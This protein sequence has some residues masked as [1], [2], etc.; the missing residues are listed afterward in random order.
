M[1]T[2]HKLED[3]LEDA[4]YQ[5][6]IEKKIALLKELAE[7]LDRPVIYQ[8]NN[9]IS[10]ILRNLE[11]EGRKSQDLTRIILRI[12]I[13]Y[14]DWNENRGNIDM[15][16]MDTMQR[17]INNVLK[18]LRFEFSRFNKLVDKHKRLSSK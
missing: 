10:A 9:L 12:V 11:E 2:I 18:I 8:K 15:G 16:T 14:L 6:N 3:Q 4:L 13:D 17:A 1:N 7:H 5:D